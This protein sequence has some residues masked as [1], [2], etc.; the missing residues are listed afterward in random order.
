MVLKIPLVLL[1]GGLVMSTAGCD[2]P[3]FTVSKP[4]ASMHVAEDDARA[5]GA[6]SF[7]VPGVAIDTL[8]I[9]EFSECMRSRGYAFSLP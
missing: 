5:C 9:P 4:T 2:G 8:E 7:L 3:M 6:S 1:A